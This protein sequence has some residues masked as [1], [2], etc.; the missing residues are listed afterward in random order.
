MFDDFTIISVA[1][2]LILGIVANI[3]TT[4]ILHKKSEPK[5][6]VAFFDILN[7]T[8]IGFVMIF[9]M[10]LYYIEFLWVVSGF[11]IFIIVIIILSLSITL[12]ILFEKIKFPSS[13]SLIHNLKHFLPFILLLILLY[14]TNKSMPRNI[15]L[16]SIKHKDNNIIVDGR[17]KESGLSVFLIVEAPSSNSTYFTKA[18]G[19]FNNKTWRAEMPLGGGSGTRFHIYSIA[20]DSYVMKIIGNNPDIE[21]V[22]NI[23]TMK[24][25]C[26]LFEL[27]L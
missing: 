6:K 21:L 23:A 11:A 18:Y 4:L 1:G 25:N 12:T 27:Y 16:S 2:S 15:Y 24:S 10:T 5:P 14:I 9:F 13:N 22:K 20:F 7:I 3:I 19:P 26:K 17:V 8:S